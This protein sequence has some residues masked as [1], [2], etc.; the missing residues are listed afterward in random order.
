MS[1]LDWLDKIIDESKEAIGLEKSEELD[2]CVPVIDK[3][4]NHNAQTATAMC[5]MYLLSDGDAY[6]MFMAQ[7]MSGAA[8]Y[9]EMMIKHG[10][11]VSA[12][13]E[14]ELSERNGKW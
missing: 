6:A 9:R 14:K 7:F 8:I 12:I 3:L 4:F 2:A 5:V 1:E 11:D 10:I 13:E